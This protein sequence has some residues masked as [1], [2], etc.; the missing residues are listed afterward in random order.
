M[1]IAGEHARPG[2]TDHPAQQRHHAFDLLAETRQDRLLQGMGRLL[3]AKRN[4]V[5]EALGL[6]GNA[7]GGIQQPAVGLAQPRLVDPSRCPLHCGTADANRWFAG[8]DPRQAGQ[9]HDQRQSDALQ[10]GIFRC[11]REGGIHPI[12][13]NSTR[14][15]ATSHSMP[16]LG[17]F[18]L[19]AAR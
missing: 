12:K 1:R 6:P 5:G 3:H 14:V 11:C 4:L 8:R 13:Y 2:L 17:E 18:L 10:R 15:L 9:N 19:R 7:A 16:A